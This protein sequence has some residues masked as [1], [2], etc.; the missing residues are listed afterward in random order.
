MIKTESILFD[1]NEDEKAELAA[2]AAQ[3]GQSVP[4]RA[5][6][7]PSITSDS[8]PIA[9]GRRRQNILVA[10]LSILLAISNFVW[11]WTHPS[12]TPLT[13]LSEMEQRSPPIDVIGNNGKPTLIDFWAPWC[14]N[15]KIMAPTLQAL[16]HQYEGKVNF[17][18]MNGADT[19]RNGYWV[20]RFGVDAI[21]HLALVSS[22]GLIE[23]ALIGIIPKHVLA[24]D[25]DV[26]IENSVASVNKKQCRDRFIVARSATTRLS[27]TESDTPSETTC[28]DTPISHKIL[29]YQMYDAFASRPESRYLRLD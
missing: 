28:T 20:D 25:L 10:C 24:A 15:C 26:M 5:L 7:T 6:T 8:N 13:I 21:P 22:D 17:V 12:V 23:T 9:K 29:P 1:K 16:E 27:S 2:T 11:Q 18:M 14:E 19:V 3:F 4:M